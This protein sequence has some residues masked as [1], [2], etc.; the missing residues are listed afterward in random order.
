MVR[1]QAKVWVEA[2]ES[3]IDRAWKAIK[4]TL[5]QIGGSEAQGAKA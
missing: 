5:R 1:E 3:L 4:G 2:S